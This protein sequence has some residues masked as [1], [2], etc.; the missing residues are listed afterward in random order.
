MKDPGPILCPGAVAVRGATI[1]DVASPRELDKRFSCPS[2]RKLEFPRSCLLPGLVDA[3]THPI[4]AGSRISEYI[5]RARGATYLEIHKQGGGILSTVK[6]TRGASD[7]E[8]LERL[9][10]NLDRM[11]VHGTTTAEAK[12]GY[13]LNTQEEI[14]QLR[15]LRDVQREH[16]LELAITFLG[17]HTIPEEYRQSRHEYVE[18]IQTEMLPAIGR[19]RL[20]EFMDIFCE[21]GAFSL[22]ESRT[23]L[24]AGKKS[25]LGLKIHAEQFTSS[26][27]AVMAAELGAVSCDHL[28]RLDSTHIA[29]LKSFDTIAVFMPST[30]LF[31]GIHEY[32]PAR[33]AIDAG[34]AVAL[35]TDFNAG[36]CLS[37]S[38]PM[39]MSLSI[40]QMKMEP[41][42]ALIA[43]TVNAAHS[44][45]RG[46]RIGSIEKGKQA[47]I[48]ILDITDYREWLY[49][50]GVNL[51]KAVMKRG[52]MTVKG[53]QATYERCGVNPAES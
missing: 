24:E 49:H 31:L 6:S 36:S 8:L 15:L 33:Q 11:L 22:S 14:R 37:E 43:A 51:V 29:R 32:G 45:R 10:A 50:F 23:L 5:L 39:T 34:I 20:A 13:G 46:D 25:G 30:E 4:F 3:H 1:I 35:G 17:A 26:G 18:K 53:A 41:E 47:D 19:E 44:I 16:P 27:S 9:K 40:L 28:L 52:I 42:E 7:Q 21:E 12:S 2:D 48:L 38:L